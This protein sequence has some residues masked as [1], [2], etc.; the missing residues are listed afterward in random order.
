MKCKM[1]PNV[2]VEEAVAMVL[3]HQFVSV[4]NVNNIM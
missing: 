2:P 3:Q 1:V 4:Q